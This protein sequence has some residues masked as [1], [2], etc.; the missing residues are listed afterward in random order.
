M[1]TIV[2]KNSNNQIVA[3]I[4]KSRLSARAEAQTTNAVVFAEVFA[5]LVKR[6]VD[7]F[8]Q[9]RGRQVLRPSLK[10]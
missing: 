2:K 7:A 1:T 9:A 5:D 4:R 10:H 6:A 8:G 3:M